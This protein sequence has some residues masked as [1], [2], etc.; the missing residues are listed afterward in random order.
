MSSLTSSSARLE[1]AEASSSLRLSSLVSSLARSSC[2]LRTSSSCPISETRRSASSARARAVSTSRSRPRS[3]RP[4]PRSSCSICSSIRSSSSSFFATAAWRSSAR[5]PWYSDESWRTTARRASRSVISSGGTPGS[6][7]MRATSTRLATSSSAAR[8]A[9]ET[10]AP[11]RNGRTSNPRTLAHSTRWFFTANVYGGASCAPAGAIAAMIA[12][13]RRTDEGLGGELGGRGG[14]G[15]AAAQARPG[16][17]PMLLLLLANPSVGARIG[18]SGCRDARPT[19]SERSER[20]E[21]AL[22]STPSFEDAPP[23]L[24]CPARTTRAGCAKRRAGVVR[25]GEILGGRG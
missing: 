3:L 12:S 15:G 23:R 25:L 4:P 13:T 22:A 24:A 9:G 5:M 21:R 18:K 16:P 10:F 6:D 8:S 19:K 11:E 14:G 1:A 2:S 17:P 20:R 7:S